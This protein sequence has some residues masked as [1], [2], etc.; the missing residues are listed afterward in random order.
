MS[1]E[2]PDT[3]DPAVRGV[4]VPGGGAAR[5]LLRG[6]LVVVAVLAVAALTRTFVVEAFYVPSGSMEPT[7]QVG[8]RLVVER[9]GSWLGESPERGDVVVF[10]D[11]GGWLED[12]GVDTGSGGVLQGALSVLGLA[13]SDDHLVKR[14]VGVAGDVIHCCDDRGRLEVN[15][16]AV[17]E[18][19]Y[20]RIDDTDCY[21]P[22]TGTCD[23]TAGPVP[24]GMLFVM[25]DHRDASADSSTRM[26]SDAVTDCVE[27]HEWV[28]VDDVV[29]RVLTVAWPL[30]D[31][32]AP[33]GGEA[34]AA[35]PAAEAS[36]SSGSTEDPSGAATASAGAGE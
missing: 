32:G 10:T 26:C 1:S 30:G 24:D 20:A 27:G 13:S 6:V 18:T 19:A 5:S 34:L 9:W 15:G 31:A 33:A 11:P 3:P 35:V 25:G 36:E 7:L 22:M 23:W 29:G 28:P 2:L 17:D 21:G 8:D 16:V 12:D 14:V 4:G